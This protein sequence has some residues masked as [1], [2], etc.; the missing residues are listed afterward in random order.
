MSKTQPEK[1][2]TLEKETAGHSKSGKELR[3]DQLDNVAGGSDP[4][5]E[6]T[7]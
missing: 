6:V 1:E 5:V 3:D 4:Q 2:N 7:P